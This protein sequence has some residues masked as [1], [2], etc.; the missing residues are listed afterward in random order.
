LPFRAEGDK[1]FAS[2]PEKRGA[3][4]TREE[5]KII[6]LTTSS[7]ALVHLFEGVIPPLIPLLMI[8]FSTDYFHM[9]VVVTV[10]SY[11]FGFGSLPAGFVADRLGPARLITAYLFGTGIASLL[12]IGAS[13]LFVYAILMGIVGLFCSPY[14][15]AS[16][17][18]ISQAIKEKGR[19]FGIHGIAGSL[20][21]A[22]VPVISAWIGTY[23]GWRGPHILYGLFAIAVGIYSFGIP[24]RSPPPKGETVSKGKEGAEQGISI[25]NLSIFFIS[26]MSLG[27]TYKGIMTFLPAYM[28]E[29]VTI[30]GM[31]VN[32]VTLGGTVT[33]LALLSG[34]A[35]QYLAGRL[36]DR[37]RAERLYLVS[38]IIG[39]VCVFV[40]AAASNILLIAA[41]VI[42]AFFY[43]ATQP[44]QNYLLSRYFPRHRQGMGYGIHFFVTF[45]IGSTAAAVSGYFADNF[46]LSS[47][48]YF[49]GA[50]FLLSCAASWLLL[51]RTRQ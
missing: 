10:L 35:G 9:G 20:G 7:H 15:P 43:F 51:I 39:T 12:V 4:L 30:A 31:S 27:L 23:L 42:Y 34:A 19:V 46:G 14:H 47:V 33:T 32:K 25:T 24:R 50:C 38:I 45:G 41:S 28:G 44:I 17:A 5:K 40:M 6:K 22:L 48:F 8:E 11:A 49:V 26:A 29:S 18:L 13:S 16:N 36:V 21:V 2:H 37:L 3:A 1:G